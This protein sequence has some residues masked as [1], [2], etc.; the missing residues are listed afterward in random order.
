MFAI[1]EETSIAKGIRRIVAL[2]GELARNAHRLADDLD[3][4][5]K[6]LS[7][8]LSSSDI[9]TKLKQF[10]KELE[11]V[12]IPSVRKNEIL[13]QFDTIRKEFDDQSKAL[14]AEQVKKAIEVVKSHFDSNPDSVVFIG[15]LDVG[16]NSK[17]GENCALCDISARVIFNQMR[18]TG[19]CVGHWPRQ[20]T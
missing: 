6:A 17:V 4:K 1:T 15:K 5:V 16:S 7:K 13:K 2:T 10:A 20:R 19:D 8:E 11:S 18:Y 12:T 14:K 9:E 3:A